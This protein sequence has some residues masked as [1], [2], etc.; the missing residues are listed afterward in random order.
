[1]PVGAKKIRAPNGARAGG[2]NEISDHAAD[3]VQTAA[4]AQAE[5][6]T[7][8]QRVRRER[9]ERVPLHRRTERRGRAADRRA[10]QKRRRLPAR[11]LPPARK[12]LYRRG[13]RRGGERPA[14]AVR[15]DARRNGARRARKA[16]TAAQDGREE[17]DDLGQYPR[18][19]QRLGR[20]LRIFGQTARTG[21][22]D[23]AAGVPRPSPISTARARRAGARWSR[24]S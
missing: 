6:G 7:A 24:T 19:R 1:M 16:L 9:A 23:R 12:L 20:R 17:P 3:P 8:C 10:G 18:G 5:R 21:G 14:R 22:R 4:A 13:V 15:T 2:K 11:Y